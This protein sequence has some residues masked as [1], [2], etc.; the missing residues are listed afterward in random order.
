MRLKWVDPGS[1][2]SLRARRRTAMG[3]A[4]LATVVSSVWH[5]VYYGDEWIVGVY[6]VLKHA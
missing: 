1:D 3:R 4:Y 6:D 5:G 2:A